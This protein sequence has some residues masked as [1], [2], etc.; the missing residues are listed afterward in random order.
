LMSM[1]AE[2]RVELMELYDPYDPHMMSVV[3]VLC[4]VQKSV[5]VERGT[6]RGRRAKSWCLL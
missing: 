4:C 3:V 5:V 2:E 6:E 1:G